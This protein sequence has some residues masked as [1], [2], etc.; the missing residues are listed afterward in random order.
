MKVGLR[1]LPGE[2]LLLMLPGFF[3]LLSCYSNTWWSVG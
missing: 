3:F 1:Y 2:L